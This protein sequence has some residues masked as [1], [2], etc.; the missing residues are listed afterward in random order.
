MGKPVIGYRF[1]IQ[2][3][4]VLSAAKRAIKTVISLKDYPFGIVGT[5]R[6]EKPPN[7]Q[8]IK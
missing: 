8:K 6:E 1:I 7:G 3:N 5:Q 4:A 2:K